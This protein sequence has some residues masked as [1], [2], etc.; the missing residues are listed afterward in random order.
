MELGSVNSFAVRIEHLAECVA[1]AHKVG[2]GPGNHRRPWEL[3][4]Q[5]QAVRVYAETLP[6]PYL[7]G[8]ADASRRTARIMDEAGVD[9][10]TAADWD[11]VARFLRA[12]A[13]ALVEDSSIAAITP[14]TGRSDLA[15]TATG[16]VRYER[17]AELLHTQG[18]T[19]LGNAA[20][21]VVCYCQERLKVVPTT[22]EL[23]WIISVAVN[24]PIERLSERN[25]MSSRGMYHRLETLWKRLG[26]STPVQ[27]VALAVQRGWIASPPYFP[28][29]CRD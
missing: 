25:N 10:P 20:S 14:E 3:D 7:R 17:L 22:Q 2:H 11:I 5:H 27:G 16:L 1:E 12:T 28:R 24:E 19:R 21:T 18:I 26:V 23:E 29:Q 9:E 8:M 13:D 15:S 4:F 6:P